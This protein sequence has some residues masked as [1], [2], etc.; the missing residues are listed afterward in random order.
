MAAVP[1]DGTTGG[2]SFPRRQTQQHTLVL[3]SLLLPVCRKRGVILLRPT[4]IEQHDVH[5]LVQLAARSSAQ[6]VASQHLMCWRVPLHLRGR[7]WTELLR[8]ECAAQITDML[9]LDTSCT[10]HKVLAKFEA[11]C[12]I[13]TYLRGP[14][15][16]DSQARGN[17]A[18]RRSTRRN[19]ACSD[20]AAASSSGDGAPVETL[21]F[22]LPRFQ[23]EFELRGGAT[24]QACGGGE[25]PHG[26]AYALA[27]N[28]YS[29]YELAPDQQLLGRRES[30]P[31]GAVWTL[32]EFSQYLVL[33]QREG[34]RLE[35]GLDKA[36]QLVLVP[37]GRVGADRSETAAAGAVV[38]LQVPQASGA[39][40]K[41]RRR[42]AGL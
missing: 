39:E 14:S 34:T 2:V 36:M 37:A 27:S 9:L 16:H 8:A 6:E 40:L 19:G 10:Q 41:V 30:A 31:G 15:L 35:V 25:L 3:L 4:S 12:F 29:G 21:V 5:F 32:P 42:G 23:L 18:A 24:P 33:Q 13:H 17:A 28:N 1:L 22:E 20:V 26:A 11:P 38:T 7:L